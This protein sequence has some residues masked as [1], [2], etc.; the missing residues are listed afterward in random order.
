M[1]RPGLIAPLSPLRKIMFFA[2]LALASLLLFMLLASLSATLIWG[3]N[4]TDLIFSVSNLDQPE[5]IGPL[6]YFQ[7]INQIGLFILPPLLFAY[8]ADTKPCSYL[9]M[10]IGAGILTL[11]LCVLILFSSFPFVQWMLEVN[12]MM[13][14][15]SW[16]HSLEV[17]MRESEANAEKLTQ[18]F[19]ET[20]TTGGI[21]INIIMIAVLPAL[22]EELVFRG[23]LQ[24]VFNEWFKNHHLAV[25]TTAIIFSSLHLQFY[26]FLPRTALGI[27]FGYLFVVTGSIWVPVLVHFINNAM[28]VVVAVFFRT[29]IAETDYLEFGRVSG[30]WWVVASFVLVVLLFYSLTQHLKLHPSRDVGKAS[31]DKTQTED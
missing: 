9:K 27:V 21:I 23:V 16:L 24:R 29:G 12:Q 31:D 5:A 25:I 26:G 20:K 2:L 17:W 3:K 30:P 1:I 6:K 22:G 15:P 13:K 11:V 18:A 10:N 7:V 19:L 14:F 4:L 8:L 28:A